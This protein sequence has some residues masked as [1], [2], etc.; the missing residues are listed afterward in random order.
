MASIAVGA[1]LAGG[2]ELGSLGSVGGLE[3]LEGLGGPLN[4]EH[5]YPLVSDGS[6]FFGNFFENGGFRN[7]EGPRSLIGNEGGLDAGVNTNGYQWGV[8]GGDNF[9][10]GG[11]FD[12]MFPAQAGR[13]PDG[14][15]PS[16][17]NSSADKGSDYAKAASGPISAAITGGISV[18]NAKIQSETTK[19]IA[20]TYADASMSNAKTN[21]ESN[22]Q[23]GRIENRG[24]VLGQF[25]RADADLHRMQGVSDYL[26]GGGYDMRSDLYGQLNP[27]ARTSQY[28]GSGSSATTRGS[29]NPSVGNLGGA[30]NS[31]YGPGNV[32]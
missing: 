1:E 15:Q 3:S 18:K 2:A 7:Q 8:G 23:R 20:N 30:I 19:A 26:G 13:N 27:K 5:P 32:L 4:F 22:I 9:R 24:I 11:L 17:S 31:M 14:S 6:S 12:Q 29:F 28:A 25:A 16:Q 10:R 21:K